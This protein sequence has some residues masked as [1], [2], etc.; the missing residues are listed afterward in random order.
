MA[1]HFASNNV[2]TIICSRNLERLEKTSNEI[3]E[4]YGNKV[5]FFQVDVA[6]LNTVNNFYK[7]LNE[8]NIKPDILVNNAAGNFVSRTEDL[9]PNAIN[10]IIDIVL[11][12][13]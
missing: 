10:K 3:N 13:L 1:E 9:S 4:K 5:K 7:N 8:Q 2:N 6:D 11:K 12:V